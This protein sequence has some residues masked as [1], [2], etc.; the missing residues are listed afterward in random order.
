MMVQ[1]GYGCLASLQ[2]HLC[3]YIWVPYMAWIPARRLDHITFVL[4]SNMVVPW[5]CI[6][7]DL[8]M[9]W[10]AEH[11]QSGIEAGA[12]TPGSNVLARA[13]ASTKAYT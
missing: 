1:N 6:S 11:I 13:G 8:S 2:L 3:Y 10:Q 4:I 7:S 12:S 5:S 9:Q